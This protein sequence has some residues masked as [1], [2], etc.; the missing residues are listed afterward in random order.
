MNLW[1]SPN[2]F[3]ICL[4]IFHICTDSPSHT[5]VSFFC[6]LLRMNGSGS[7]CG[8][9]LWNRRVAGSSPNRTKYR[10][11]LQITSRATAEMSWRDASNPQP[12]PCVGTLAGDVALTPVHRLK[13]IKVCLSFFKIVPRLVQT[14]NTVHS[15]LFS[16]LQFYLSY[17]HRRLFNT[18]MGKTFAVKLWLYRLKGTTS[19]RI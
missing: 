4:L 6:Q 9:S 1:S 14:I 15:R 12:L 8:T 2:P 3:K 10:P 11:Q 7:V 5:V 13:K 17:C 16:S 18:S 19:R